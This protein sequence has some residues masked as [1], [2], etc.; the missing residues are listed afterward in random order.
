MKKLKLFFALFAMLA[1]G[2]TNAWGAEA[3]FTIKFKDNGSDASTVLTTA[4]FTKQVAEGTDLIKSVSTSYCY[5]GTGGLKCSSNKN[6]GTFTLTLNNSYT[7]SKIVLSVKNKNATTKTVKVGNTSFSTSDS[8]NTT[9]FEDLAFTGTETTSDQITVSLAGTKSSKRVAYIASMTVYYK[10]DESG[11]EEPVISVEPK[12]VDFGTKNIYFESEKQGSLEIDITG[13]NLTGDVSAAISG[14]DASVFTL[15]KTTF[16]P[17]SGEV[18]EKLSVSYSV[19]EVKTYTATLTLSSDGVD[20]IELPITLTTVNKKPTIYTKVTDAATLSA[21]DKVILV[22]ESAK[23]AAGKISNTAGGY[24]N[25]IDITQ[26][27]NTTATPATASITDEAVVEY[28]LGGTT[29]AWELISAGNKLSE[30][31]A[32]SSSSVDLKANGDTKWTISVTEGNATIK[33]TTNTIQYNEANPR[34]KTYTSGQKTIQLYAISVPKYAVNFTQPEG[35]ELSV[36]NG[37][38]AITSGNTFAEGIKLTVTATPANGYEGGTVVVK[39]ADGN[40]VT[41][42]VY[43][44]GVL[45]MPAYAVTISATFEEKPCELLAKP[46]V[47]ATTTYSSATLTWEAVAN[48][49]KYSVKVG[50]AD[51]VETTATSYEVTGLTAETEYTYQVQAIAEADQDTYCDSEVAEGTF[52]T[53]TAPTATLTLKD[54]VGETTK[55]G[56]LNSTITLPTTA[57]ECSKTF[58]GWDADKNCNHAPTYAPGAEYTLAAEPQTLYAVYAD[59]KESTTTEEYTFTSFSSAQEVTLGSTS[60]RVKLQKGTGST[61]PAWNPGSA[62]ARI[63]AKGLLTIVASKPIVKVVYSYTINANNS[64]KKPTVDGVAGKNSAGTWDAATKTWNGSDTEIILSTSG[65]AGNVGFKKIVV[66]LG[67]IGYENYSTKCAAAAVATVNPTSVT[68]NAA[69]ANGEVEVTYENVNTES[70][71]VALYNDEAC[72]EAFTDGWLTAALDGDKITYTVA[73]NTTYAKRKAYI[74]LTAPETNGATDP[75]VVV[76]PVTQAGKDKVFASLE[77][78][79]AAIT[80]TTEGVEVTVTLTNEV[81]Q[82]FYKSSSYTNGIALNVPY[83]GGVKVIEIYCKDVPAEWVK[84]GKVSGT[85]TCPWKL[86]NSTWELCPTAWTELTY[87]APATVSSIAVSGNPTKTTYIDG[88]KFDPAGLVVTATYSDAS[89]G[90]IDA[91][92]V[93]WT[94]DPA[95]LVKGQTSVKVTAKFNSVSSAA[96]EVTGLTVNDIPTKTV[97][98][99]IAEEGG[100]CYLEGIVSNIKN[101]TYGNFDLTDASGTIYVYGCLN[102]SGE[103]Q[104]FASLGVKAGDKIK[105][106]ADVYEL[107]NG[108]TEE[109]KNVQYVSHVSAASIT[110]ADITMEVEE[111]K[112]ISATVVPAE[113]EVTYTIKENTDNAI[114]LSG[115]K[116]TALAVG[117]ATITASVAEGAD[118]LANSVDFTVT[119][120]PQNIATLPFAFDD[121]VNDIKNTLGMSQKNLGTDYGSSPKLKFDDKDDYVIIHFDKRPGILSYDIKANTGSGVFSGEFAVQESADGVTYRDLV[122]YSTIS[123]SKETKTHNCFDKDTRYIK[124]IFVAKDNGNVALGNIKIETSVVTKV[125]PSVEKGIFSV[126][127]GKFVQFSTGNLQYEVGT[128]TWSFASEQYEVIGGEAYTGSNNTNYGMNV[129]GYTGKLDLFAWSCD[130]KFGVNPSNADADYTGEFADWGNLVNEEGWYTLTATE[131][132]YLLNRKKD[133][134]KLWALA[135]VCGMN[136]LILL[137]DNWNTSTTLEYGYVPADW[138]Y[139]KNQLDATAWANLEAGGAVFLPE[140]GSRVGGYGNK[141]GFDGATVETDDYFHVDNVGDYGYY[142]LNT[143]DTRPAY[144]HCASYLILPGWSEGATDAN[145]DDICLQPQVWSREKRRGNSVRLVKAIEPDYTRE[146]RQGYYGTICLEN[147]GQMIG[148]S[149]FGLS[150][151]NEAQGLLYMDEADATMV[152][153]NPYIFLPNE[154][155]TKDSLY[156]FYDETTAAAKTVNGLVGSFDEVEL[157]VSETDP[158][159]IMKDNKIKKVVGANVFVSEN[160][161]YIKLGSVNPNEQAPVP[162]RRRVAIGQ[163]PQVATGMENIDASAQPVKMIIDG[164]LYILRGEKM[165]D[166]QGKL[167]K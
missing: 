159:Y 95:T 33:G 34:F 115:N 18:S 89:T 140:G 27:L 30:K 46:T 138:N 88:E 82:D 55:T 112:T 166:A 151:Y 148:A 154:R 51:A 17:N 11:S 96:Y 45:T 58:V 71:A 68:A 147:G 162:G 15:S 116:I 3:S 144:P 36:K 61:N 91:A 57:A 10:T 92:L 50:T 134:K 4:T 158:V 133:D 153:G 141:I 38:T 107:Y 105:V 113:A 20:D 23:K 142:W 72:T 66:T 13:Q 19:S 56:A 60:F 87:T 122:K 90:V 98:E 24:L 73:E 1:L 165:Y 102:A 131:M 42:T 111:V 77:A 155:A 126:G 150:Y 114:S 143:Q 12:K 152:A 7:I 52:T 83:E 146:V 37:E 40:D 132:N 167:V 43:A 74:K 48:A 63:Y 62:E 127:D 65:D 29:G 103:A 59:E 54:I 94:F 8:W 79:L 160:R 81:I 128:N 135:T 21:G 121:G 139:T 161:A 41:T 106:I 100:R 117:T 163:A 69:G 75:A 149:R 78:L 125:T 28:T 49:A 124:F 129:P 9:S 86:Y 31:T 22:Y 16:T 64:G 76:I 39:D 70:V 32:N 156:V 157:P 136:G 101:T 84:G 93:D 109:A 145:E 14:A 108:T 137:P 44:D 6:N 104:K 97:A 25:A 67:S 120:N 118:Y 123:G 164:Q 85:I 47:I 80:P 35:G 5:A 110:I 53:A 119:V 2:V 26:A 99:F 130:G